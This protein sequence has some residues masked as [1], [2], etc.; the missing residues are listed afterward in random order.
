MKRA[1]AALAALAC[2]LFASGSF[3]DQPTEWQM[4]LQQAA[5]PIMEQ[6]RWFENYTLWF[7]V[8]ITVFVLLLLIVVVVRFRALR[9]PG[10]L[11]DQPQHRDRDRL[12]R[13]VRC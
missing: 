3:A 4:D 12:D 1:F 10:S 6:I 13:S 7:I 9:Q 8:P 2:L 11:E 5:T